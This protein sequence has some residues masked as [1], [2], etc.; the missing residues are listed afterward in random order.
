MTGEQYKEIR[1]QL[2][3]SQ[4]ALA[5]RLGIARETVTRRELETQPITKEADFAIRYLLS[6]TGE[7]DA[8]GMLADLA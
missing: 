3:F 8:N 6:A 7:F 4:V 2:G 1:R 5:D